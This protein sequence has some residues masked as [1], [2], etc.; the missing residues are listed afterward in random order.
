V[1][2]ANT[3]KLPAGLPDGWDLADEAPARLDIAAILLG[4]PTSLAKPLIISS[5]EFV[6]NFVPP[7]YLLQ[8]ILLRRF[9]YSLT[10]PTGSGKTAVLLLLAAFVAQAWNLG[11]RE[12][13]KQR[14]LYM[15]GENPTDHRMRWIAM[16]DLLNFDAEA[17][18]VHFID[19][20][21]PLEGSMRRIRN[22]V[23]ALGGIG[24]VV[25]DTSPAYFEGDSENDN[26]QMLAHAHMLR[27]LVDLEDGPTVIAACHP[28][29]NADNTCLLPRGGGAF[30][31]EMDTNLVCVKKDSIIE[32]N[33][34]GKIRGIDFNP[35]PFEVATVTTPKLKDSKGRLI[36]TV[37]AKELSTM[38]SEAITKTERKH[39]DKVLELLNK[40]PCASLSE[41]AD[42]LQWRDRHGEPNKKEAQNVTDRLR[43]SKLIEPFDARE[44]WRLTDKGKKAAEKL[45]PEEPK[46]DAD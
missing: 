39:E 28:I 43:A 29:K 34:Q 12:V 3:V 6:T 23:K 5:R 20:V 9:L 11:K 46:N 32:M 36:P 8:D 4:E 25:V 35:I 24:L 7:D 37:M 41:I 1:P 16:A 26:V 45:K 2:Q 10:G 15:A 13:S 19:G 42:K 27:R 33:W 44:G 30:L 22:E 17:I 31:N 21:I 14:V 18:D 38:R 40:A